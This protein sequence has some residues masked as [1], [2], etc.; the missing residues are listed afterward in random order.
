MP[1]RPGSHGADDADA[2]DAATSRPGPPSQTKEGKLSYWQLTHER[3]QRFEIPWRDDGD[4]AER[5]VQTLHCAPQYSLGHRGAGFWVEVFRN[6]RVAPQLSFQ[7]LVTLNT[8]TDSDTV[9]VDDLPDLLS[10]LEHLAPI[11]RLSME[12][13]RQVD[14]IA[15]RVHIVAGDADAP[16]AAH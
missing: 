12:S 7:F 9:L 8:P 2:R 15:D 6:Q 1:H 3:L 13:T 14:I 4:H 5:L 16:G 11:I 10:M